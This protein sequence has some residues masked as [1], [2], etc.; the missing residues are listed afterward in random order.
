MPEIHLTHIGETDSRATVM[1]RSVLEYILGLS[2]GKHRGMLSFKADW[3]H[4]PDYLDWLADNMYARKIPAELVFNLDEPVDSFSP[5]LKRGFKLTATAAPGMDFNNV[6]KLRELEHLN[7]IL[8]MPQPEFDP[9][10]IRSILHEIPGIEGVRLGVSWQDNYSGPSPIELGD[11]ARWAQA[12]EDIVRIIS[13]ERRDVEFLCGLHLCLF[14]RSQLGRLS[15]MRV[16]W[17]IAH[18]PTEIVFDPNGRIKPCPRLSISHEKS[19]LDI[20]SLENERTEITDRLK[21]FRGLC[22]QARVLD[23]R[24]LAVGACFGGC[25]GHMMSSWRSAPA[26]LASIK[27]N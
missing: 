22:P 14:N 2:T 15:A 4:P 11:E 16:R 21:P 3:S 27:R 19:A 1:E 18:C 7:L 13:L 24:S 12:I 20:I 8:P 25:I 5:F 6:S 23:C 9:D 26:S 10:L 17:P